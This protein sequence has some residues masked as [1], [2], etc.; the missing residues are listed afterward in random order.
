[1]RNFKLKKC[2]RIHGLV[3]SPDSG[4]LLILG[5]YEAVGPDTAIRL[6][7]ASGEPGMVLSF[8]ANAFAVAADRSR[9]AIAED[10]YSRSRLP[11]VVRW[12]DPWKEKPAWHLVDIGARWP[13][14]TSA[15]A[16]SA[17]AFSA[18]AKRLKVAY[19]R[20]SMIPGATTWTFHL[21]DCRVKSAARPTVVDVDSQVMSLAAAPN[22]TQWVVCKETGR[23]TNR[24]HLFDQ[25]SGEPLQ[26]VS[27]KSA[28]GSLSFSPDGQ[29]LAAIQAREV[30]LLKGDLSGTVGLLQGHQGQLNAVAFS[31][32]SRRIL[33]A[34]HDGTVRVWDTATCRLVATFDWK[35]GNITAVACAP[36]GMTAAAGGSNGRVLVWD[37]D[38][39]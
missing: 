37:T 25:A 11:R 30:V 12:C 17:L 23:K 21:A 35:I 34:S 36:D 28:P 31:P 6:D 27:R 19:G 14:R 22:G 26:S 24:I 10:A 38:E 29:L 18:D 32:D 7:F 13:L 33:T 2:R 15:I 8:L 9:L 3:F 39:I 16:A 5:G 1:M 20:Q 4:R